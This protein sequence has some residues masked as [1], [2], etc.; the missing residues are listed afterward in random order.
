MLIDRLP[1][2]YAVQASPRLCRALCK[3]IEKSI[4]DFYKKNCSLNLFGDLI[5]ST[6]PV[7]D[8][9]GNGLRPIE[10]WE[11]LGKLSSVLAYLGPR[12]AFRA[13]T[14]I[15]IV[16]LLTAYYRKVDK[17]LLPKDDKRRFFSNV[18]FC[19]FR[20]DIKVNKTF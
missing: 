12:I 8:D 7:L 11:D 20:P 10:S 9:M 3:I 2:Y 5:K 1:E 13:S 15:K 16:R 19:D 6:K 4:N 14:N 18:K 17:D